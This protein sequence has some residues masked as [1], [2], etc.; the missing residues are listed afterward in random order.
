MCTLA[1]GR[2]AKRRERTRVAGLHRLGPPLLP[3]VLAIAVAGAGQGAALQVQAE[4]PVDAA[5]TLLKGE[6]TVSLAS[7]YK[8]L[9]SQTP[10]N[11]YVITDE[12]TRHSGATALPTVLRRIP[13]MEVMHMSGADFDLSVRGDNQPLATTLLVMVDGRSI[14]LDVQG[15]VFWKALPVTL[16]EIKR[17]E[18]RKGPA[19]AVS[20]FHALNE[21]HKEHPL[22]G[23]RLHGAIGD[24]SRLPRL[25]NVFGGIGNPALKPERNFSIEAGASQSFFNERLELGATWFRNKLEDVIDSV[26]LPGNQT[27]DQNL[28]S[29][30]AQGTETSLTA[31][32]TKGVTPSADYTYTNVGFQ[33]SGQAPGNTFYHQVNTRLTYHS[34]FGPSGFLQL[35]HIDDS[36]VTNSDFTGRQ[37]NHVNL[38]LLNGKLSY[39]VAKGIRPFVAIDNLGNS[40]YERV[41]GFPESARR[42]FIGVNATF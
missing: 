10:S 2:P 27:Q 15:P 37:P 21:R 1:K 17:I 9:I 30:T 3:P 24:K 32:L 40:N 22:A 29:L 25:L 42:F 20:I 8:Q 36:P 19:A 23:T 28:T 35:S 16:P 38:L 4:R 18:V 5:A 34:G 14:Y 7:R 12:D 11:V 31:A 26:R 13:G 6:E 33:S 39:E 41:S